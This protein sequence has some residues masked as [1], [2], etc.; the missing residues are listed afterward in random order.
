MADKFVN[1]P[2]QLHNLHTQI[3]A[4]QFDEE[5]ELELNAALLLLINEYNENRETLTQLIKDELNRLIAE[6]DK[7]RNKFTAHTPQEYRLVRV[8]KF[9]VSMVFNAGRSAFNFTTG[10]YTPC[11]Y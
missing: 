10:F 8:V 11:S 1:D 4:E 6:A 7:F 5:T 2:S 9:G 3:Y